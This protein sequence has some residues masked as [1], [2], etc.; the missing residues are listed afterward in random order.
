M[1]LP[2]Q[3]T[4]QVIEDYYKQIKRHERDIEEIRTR[5]RELQGQQVII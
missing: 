1:I 5:I 4:E 3:T 2:G